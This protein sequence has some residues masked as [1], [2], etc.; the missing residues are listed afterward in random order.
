MPRLIILADDLTGA[1]D[2]AACFAQ[3]GLRTIVMIPEGGFWL[4]SPQNP[5]SSEM[6]PYDP[7][8]VSQ[9][10]PDVLSLSTDSRQL[11]SAEAGRRVRQAVHWLQHNGFTGPDTLFYKKVDSLMRGHPAVEL[12]ASV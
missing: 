12:A 4:P 6:D 9:S 11:P 1:A 5:V 3:A 7:Q 8:A 10:M 2:T